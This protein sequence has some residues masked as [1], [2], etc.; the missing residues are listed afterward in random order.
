MKFS[1]IVYPNPS[2]LFKVV[3]ATFGKELDDIIDYSR[4]DTID[5]FAIETLKR[6][7]L[8]GDETPQDM[9]MRVA[10][11]IHGAN[12]EKTVETY[13]HMSLG[14]FTHATPTLFNAGTNL[15]QMSSCF[16]LA[17]KG[18]SIDDI[19]ET[20]KDCA[21]ISK[22]AG[23]I[24]LHIHNIR[25][26]GTPIK[27]TN[28]VSNGIVPMLRVFNNTARYV[29]QGG[30][31]R[32]GSFAIYLE[33]WHLDVEDFLEL[34]KNHGVEELR[35]RDL[36]LA[37]WVP[38]LFMKR[39]EQKGK[40]T[41]FCP[42]DT[43]DLP[44]LVGD[45]FEAAYIKYEA[46]DNIRKKEINAFELWDKILCSQS[47]TGTPYIMFKD[48]CNLKSNHKHMGTIKSS[49]LCCEVVQY[50]DSH[51]TAVCNLASIALNKFVSEDGNTYDYDRL[52]KVTRVVTRNL[53]LIIDKNY[54][55]TKEAKFANLNQR[56]I[57]I[58]V[59]G[60]ADTFQL[61]MIP[62]D[63]P[64]A[65]L[66]NT[67]IFK[68]IYYHAMD[69]SAELAKSTGEAYKTYKGSPLSQGIFQFDMWGVVPRGGNSSNLSWDWHSLREK[70]RKYGVQN[71]LLTCV[72]PTASTAQILGNA[73]SVEP[74]QSNIFSRRV[75]SGNFIVTNKHLVRVLS[76]LGMWS[77]DMKD[78]IIAS[79]G[80][81]QDHPDIPGYVKRVFKTI[82]E[83]KQKWIVDHAITRGPYVD[84]AQ[85]MSLF[86]AD[87]DPNKLSSAMFYA[88]RNGCK[89][90]I[91]YTRTLP[92]T[93]AKA[94]TAK[95]IEDCI[96][97]SS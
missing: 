57:G 76:K 56:P 48:A 24:G 1:E 77:E 59:Q 68:C 19:F 22:T 32:K 44:N 37:L 45:E 87:A 7:Y 82:W 35:A 53:N 42:K 64:D 62:Y 71:S 86:F 89:T 72:M 75:I 85:S 47:E 65:L 20:V 80:S 5:K 74:Y 52:G 55:P 23:G 78:Y 41:L 4:N 51:N 34:R 46:N 14:D 10:I 66:L 60:L 70:V 90:G 17:M 58:G 6:S 84:Q 40:W 27:K 92:K 26:K 15:E 88:W 79:R 95:K 49:N 2:E 96:S 30:G 18:D 13:N 38:D 33:P 16:L 9:W 81:I 73:E 3:H 54:Y 93:N 43:P 91:Y 61:M 25:A 31:R 29:D 8:I 12:R 94:F 11:G 83:I 63:S 97:C 21:L 69:E 50:S 36:F 28:G 39:V 67:E